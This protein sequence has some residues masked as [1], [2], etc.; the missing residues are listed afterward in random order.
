MDEMS[1]V[2][3]QHQNLRR[4]T[5]ATRAEQFAIW[6]LRLWWRAFPELQC[7][8]PELLHGFRVCHVPTAV[9]SCHRFCS[10]VLVIAGCGSG[11]ACLHFPRIAATEEQLLTTL[12]A[13]AS[14]DQQRVERVLRTFVPANV[15]VVAA[16]HALQYSQI[17]ASAGMEW[18]QP[19]RIPAVTG[20]ASDMVANAQRAELRLH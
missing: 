14:G 11:V 13:G 9:E 1:T 2:L 12:A 3:W 7:A 20:V 5:S 19:G 6:S 4:V 16:P 18:P 10:T 15:A 8:W 17:L